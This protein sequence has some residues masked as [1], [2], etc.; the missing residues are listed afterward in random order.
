MTKILFICLGNICRSPLAEADMKH[1]VNKH[2][3][4]DSF[5]IDSAGIGP[6]HIGE[7][8]DRRMVEAARQRGYIMQH[9]GRQVNSDDFAIFDLIIG[10]DDSNIDDLHDIAPDSESTQKI[11]KMTEFITDDFIAKYSPKTIDCVPDPYYGGAA[12]F[13]YAID[14]IENACEGLFNIIMNK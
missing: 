11:H 3:V 14:V 9:F 8:P 12:G 10:M 13:A 5:I 1:I 4:S 2:G 7:R 6:W